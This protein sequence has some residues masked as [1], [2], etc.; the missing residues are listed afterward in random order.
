VALSEEAAS[1]GLPMLRPLALAFPNDSNTTKVFAEAAFMFGDKFLVQPITSFG[2]RKATIYLPRLS[3][4]QWVGFFDKAIVSKGGENVT[5]AV[6]L[7][8]LPL[9]VRQN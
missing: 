5:L 4:G 8:E 9:F 3:T 1:T 7:N 2:S 6:P